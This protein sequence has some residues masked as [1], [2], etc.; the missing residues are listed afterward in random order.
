[1]RRRPAALPRPEILRD[2][3]AVADLAE[4]REMN[5]EALF[6]EGGQGVVQITRLGKPPQFLDEP[7]RAGRGTEEVR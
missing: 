7:G 3:D 1:M 6:E 4:S 5:E 2:D